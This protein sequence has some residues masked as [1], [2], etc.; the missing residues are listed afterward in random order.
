M[1]DT[2]FKRR[3]IKAR[4]DYISR[5]F[6]R[7]NDMQKEAVLSTEGALLLLAGAGSGKTTVLIN[8]IANLIRYGRASDT[9]ELPEGLTAED[10]LFLE[11]LPAAPSP[12]ETARARAL[13]AF[14]PVEPWRII[15]ITFT[16]KA[17]EELKNRLAAMLGPGAEGIWAMTF[18]SAC[19]RILRRHA[20]RLG[21]S[22][23]F[24]I[25]DQDDALAVM[26]RVVREL[27]IDEKT[28]PPKY[29]LSQISS[30]KD[31]LLSPA[32][33]IEQAD[34]GFDVRKKSVGK[35]YAEYT[36]RL[37]AAD[38]VDFDDLISL[39]VELFRKNA[40]IRGYY[41]EFFRYILVDEYQDTDNLQYLLAASIA[42]EDGNICVVGDDDQSIYKFRGATIEN[43]LSFE[44]QYKNARCIKLEQNYRSTGNILD[45]ANAVI[46]H[47]SSRK[48]KRLWTDQGSGEKLKFY[49]ADSD[50]DEAAYITRQILA[51]ITEGRR[52]NDYAVLYRMNS[53]SNRLEFAM[54][55]HGI[56]YRIIGGTRFFERAEIKDIMAY[57]CV[58]QNPDDDLRLFRIINVPA[59]GIGQ[60]TLERMRNLC[61]REQKSAYEVAKNA[62]SYEE[63]R[64]SAARLGGFAALIEEFR[65]ALAETPLDEFYDM[66]LEKT[67]YIE[68]LGDS[69]ESLARKDNI[70]ELKSNIVSFMDRVEEPSLS[71]FLDETAL[72]TDL[73]R[74]EQ[75]DDSVVMMT[76]HSAKGLEFPEVFIT[77]MEDGIFPSLRSI[78]EA[79]EMEEERRLC[80]VAITRAKKRLTLTAARRRMM[81][82]RTSSNMVSRFIDEIPEETITG[83]ETI[84]NRRGSF[85]SYGD[86]DPEY[87]EYT[88]RERQEGYYDTSPSYSYGGTQEKRS[89]YSWNQPVR[90]YPSHT[91]VGGYSKKP[92]A[93][94]TKPISVP[95]AA[96]PDIKA[97]DAVTHKAFG[98]GTVAKVTP[99]PGDALLEINFD[100]AGTKRLML[101]TASA[102]L[103]KE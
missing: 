63:L 46:K 13:C 45:A 70:L 90:T 24:T 60:T 62:A 15:A 7:L 42:G 54:K 27:N 80:Y 32:A 85:G 12:A 52:F 86:M 57:L 84:D 89:G 98:R 72:Y 40:D 67:K 69:D 23:S 31:A 49:M 20:D 97:G 81:Y 26:K 21:I 75:G 71:L 14:K 64:T 11:T 30:A 95:T 35:A 87:M 74:Y 88:R 39:T 58:I 68:A 36:R 10:L 91:G 77:G 94:H 34:A 93:G 99:M 33:Y 61:A 37:R 22:N 28:L 82:G 18:H 2:D 6:S 78:G 96:L 66:V 103:K 25:Y 53:Q 65:A 73:D 50:D 44:E 55:R 19:A 8:R 3:F 41:Q 102:F 51:G 101:K 47:N 56:P 5:D 48:G 29:I 43:I 16:N 92:A 17:A 59:R 100:S 76:M 4:R 79:E 9:D 1:Y 38:A 83:T